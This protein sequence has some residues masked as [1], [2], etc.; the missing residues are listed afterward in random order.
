MGWI[1]FA[2]PNQQKKL[3]AVLV[4]EVVVVS[5]GFFAGIFKFTASPSPCTGLPDIALA[6][7]ELAVSI[8]PIAG[9]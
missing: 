4:V 9:L 1:K 6:E 5:V 7:Y 8:K 2:D 3:F